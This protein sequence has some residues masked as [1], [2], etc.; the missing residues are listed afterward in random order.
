MPQNAHPGF[1]PEQLDQLHSTATNATPGPWLW[2]TSNSYMRLS[3]SGDGDVMHGERLHDG[4]CT[5]AVKPNDAKFS[6]TFDPPAVLALIDQARRAT[7][8]NQ[9]ERS[10]YLLDLQDTLNQL[11]TLVGVVDDADKLIA[12]VRELALGA[13]ASS[14]DASLGTAC[15]ALR[16]AVDQWSQHLGGSAF[17]RA[18]VTIG[19]REA[20]NQAQRQRG[21]ISQYSMVYCE[22]LTATP[23]DFNSAID[24]LH[25]K[26]SLVTTPAAYRGV[27]ADGG[28]SL[29]LRGLRLYLETENASAMVAFAYSDNST[30]WTIALD[31]QGE[32][33]IRHLGRQNAAVTTS[34][35]KSEDGA[36]KALSRI[37]QNHFGVKLMPA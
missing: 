29:V 5:V 12:K 14:D 18:I 19:A 22:A 37:A 24:A 31:A 23:E 28:T 25:R 3:A 11:G 30:R 8:G 20:L 1:S 21:R 33:L 4:V 9:P 2:W 36:I 6:E 32:S 10:A 15:I 27:T 13:A 35:C 34:H 26:F 17:A 16:R 7:S